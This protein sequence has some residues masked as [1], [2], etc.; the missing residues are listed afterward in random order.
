LGTKS[1]GLGRG[2]D[3]LIPRPTPTDAPQGPVRHL[4][5]DE[6]RPNPYQPRAPAADETLSELAKSI[7]THG[8]L[9]PVIVRR[10]AAG[11][12]LAAGERRWRA[13]Q[14]AGLSVIPAIVR[15][16][17]DEQMLQVALVENLQR[18]DINPIDA[19]KAYHRLAEEFGLSHDDIAE[20]VGKSRV[21]VS[22]TLRLLKLPAE[23]QERIRAGHLSEGHGRAL[24]ALDSPAAILEMAARIEREGLSVRETERQIRR[25]QR[26]GGLAQA[27]VRQPRDPHLSELEQ[28]LQRILGTRVEVRHRRGGRGTIVI[29]YFSLDE[30]KRLSELLCS[31]G[32]AVS[33]R[34]AS[35]DE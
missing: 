24:L 33:V 9:Q 28:E 6:I 17:T 25:M 1:R 14:L 18:E 20:I 21:A 19:A 34:R 29:S 23:V 13:A 30:L 2:L 8:V 31:L 10:T 35:S 11:Y 5:V 27:P 7:R 4:R 12:E 26:A 16:Y 15:S 3:S 32:R 22:N